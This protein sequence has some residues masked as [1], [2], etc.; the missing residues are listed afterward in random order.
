[1]IRAFH[2]SEG[3][4][5]DAG[6]EGVAGAV[7]LDLVEPDEAERARASELIG[8]SLPT[9]EDQ[10]EIEQ[11]S[12]LYLVSG[13]PVMT[14]QIPAGFDG[15]AAALEPVSFVLTADRLVTL[16]HHTPRP[17]DTY[18]DRA[19]Q[20]SLGCTSAETV[21]AGLLEAIVD[22]LA[23]ITEQAGR[24]IDGLSRAS[25]DPAPG[26]DP[27]HQHTLRAIG[28]SDGLVMQLRESLLTMERLLGFLLPVLDQRGAAPE[29]RSM[30]KSFLRDVRTIAEHAGFL[31]QKT[32][33]LLD[34]TLGMIEIEQAN[35]IKIFSV[36]AV[37]FLPPTLIASIYGM[38]F[39]HMPE[40]DWRLGYP[41]ALALMV[42]SVVAA[43]VIF[44]RK[45]WFRWR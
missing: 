32:A 8:L 11:S 37:I 9:R 18:P 5:R 14:A 20:A 3:R 44:R 1:M 35:I 19:A 2:L 13:V 21:L 12:R 41:M 7:W 30:V 26:D 36:V 23:D 34:A 31:Q 33:L 43:L 29:L 10:Q 38:N 42:A 4:L 17:F 6:P 22:R 28:L 15:R 24:E 25:F 40:L 16:R 39:A 27:D 45:G